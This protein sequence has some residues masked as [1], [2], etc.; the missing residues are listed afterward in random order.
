[1]MTMGIMSL[2]DMKTMSTEIINGVFVLFDKT[3]QN[4]PY[5]KDS[6]LYKDFVQRKIKERRDSKIDEIL[7]ESSDK[8]NTRTNTRPAI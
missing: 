1:M 3:N 8:N 2:M 5:S 6:D 4:P 7:N